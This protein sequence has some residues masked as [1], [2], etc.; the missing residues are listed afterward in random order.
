MSDL[1]AIKQRQQQAWADGD[2]SV[3]LTAHLIVGELLCEAVDI[4]PGQAVLDVAT[5]SGNAALAAARRGGQVTG[6]DFVPALLARGEERAAAERLSITF[7][8][9]DAERLPFDDRTFDVVLSTFG[10]IFAPDQECAARELLR[11]CRPGGRIGLANWTPAG[12]MGQIF[13]ATA[14]YAPPPPGLRPAVL[15]G[16]EDRL[17]EL[18]GSGVTSLQTTVRH[19]TMRSASEETWLEQRRKYSGPTRKAIEAMDGAQ[20]EAFERDL[21]AIV[22]RHNRAQD[23]TIIIPSEYLEVVAVR[24]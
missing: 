23:G 11:V 16:I 9:A 19:S 1:S 5:G 2:F 4:H 17:R 14:R 12:F 21:L 8:E 6:I 24:R 3:I 7:C 13:A 15:W 10:V 18:L 22:R 20:R